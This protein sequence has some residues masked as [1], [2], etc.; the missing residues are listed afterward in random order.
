MKLS[1]VLNEG[2]LDFVGGAAGELGRMAGRSAPVRAVRNVIGAG[3][4][5][6]H[7]AN[8]RR[9]LN[10]LVV[11]FVRIAK[12]LSKLSGQVTPP[13]VQQAPTAKPV[14]KRMPP[15]PASSHVPD[16]FRTNGTPSMS[17]G[18]YDFASF[19]KQ[20][21]GEQLAEGPIDFIRGA[22]RYVGNSISNYMSSRQHPIVKGFQNM[23]DAGH[24]ASQKGDIQKQIVLKQQLLQLAAQI[25]TIVKQNP[26]VWP[27][28][29]QII[30][31]STQNGQQIET[32]LRQAMARASR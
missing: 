14:Q 8:I 29:Q 20:F 21:N 6:S 24:A 7:A 22:G 26:A 19:M 9:P 2:P 18:G 28:V 13:T 27:Q 4:A 31:N 3:Q 17:N 5:A 12:K 30:K 25:Q 16:A 11:Q 1:D 10:D 23:V 15:P 32:Q